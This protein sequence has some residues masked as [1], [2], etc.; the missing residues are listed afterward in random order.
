MS[1]SVSSFE[2]RFGISYPF[3]SRTE[4]YLHP[5]VPVMRAN[6]SI[7]STWQ[8]KGLCNALSVLMLLFA[9]ALHAEQVT[10]SSSNDGELDEHINWVNDAKGSSPYLEVYKHIFVGRRAND[11]DNPVIGPSMMGAIKFDVSSLAGQTLTKA[12]LRLIQ[13]ADATAMPMRPGTSFAPTTDVYGVNS[14]EDFDE[15]NSSWT[16]YVGGQ[17]DASRNSFLNSGA[18]TQLGAM[19]NVSNPNGLSGTGAVTTFTDVDLTSL[20]QGWIS[21]SK[22]NLGLLLVNSATFTGAPAAP[23]DIVARY[24]AHESTDFDGP[25]LILEYG[26]SSVLD[27]DFNSDG[28]VDAADYTVWRDGLGGDYTAADY[29][30]WKLHFGESN[31][32]NASLVGGAAAVPEPGTLL[33]ALAGLISCAVFN[34]RPR[35]LLHSLKF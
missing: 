16:T 35:A 10:I 8:V 19:T 2:A 22:P 5:E 23:G 18:I 34:F 1:L 21:G 25:Q 17:D 24:A 15:F 13:T 20:V 9:G 11:Y 33:V 30:L 31:S 4:I 7:Q 3:R 26:T 12:T 14:G 29:N 32:G 6:D 27:G 28:T